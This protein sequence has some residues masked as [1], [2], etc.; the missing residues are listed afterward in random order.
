MRARPPHLDQAF[1][2]WE[3]GFSTEGLHTYLLAE[4]P[5]TIDFRQ[6]DP[7]PAFHDIQFSVEQIRELAQTKNYPEA[8][9]NMLQRFQPQAISYR[10]LNHSG[11][12]PSQIILS[13]I[14]TNRVHWHLIRDRFMDWAKRQASAGQS[15]NLSWKQ[16]P[17]SSSM[18]QLYPLM[19][20]KTI[21]VAP[22]EASDTRRQLL[23]PPISNPATPPYLSI[24]NLIWHPDVKTELLG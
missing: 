4:S 23:S 21:V 7:G 20:N 17:E 18:V 2:S 14:H 22:E 15:L 12:F 6:L 8:F 11:I 24:Q 19:D 1:E 5:D 10:S 13:S 3:S 9:L 16:L